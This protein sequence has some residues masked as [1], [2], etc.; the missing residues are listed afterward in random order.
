M[1]LQGRKLLIV[2]DEEDIREILKEFFEGEGLTVFTAVHGE[3]A[4]RVLDQVGPVDLVLLDLMMP[5]MSGEEFVERKKRDLRY[6]ETPVVI[7]SADHHTQKKAE[8]LEINHFM[9]K[10]LE[11]NSLINMMERILHG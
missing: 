5:I 9:R 4:L 3:D 8:A 6:R 7:M 1:K 2:E 10:P 11:L